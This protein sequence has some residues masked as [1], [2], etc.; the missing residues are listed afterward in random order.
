M[1][2]KYPL[3]LSLASNDGATKSIDAAPV[4]LHSS[5]SALY[6]HDSQALIHIVDKVHLTPW[7][8]PD[9]TSRAKCRI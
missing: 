5:S 1:H 6:H 2:L 9:L 8:P 3:S 7:S 4:P